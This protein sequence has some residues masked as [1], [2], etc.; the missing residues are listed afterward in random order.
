MTRPRAAYDF[1]AIRARM[2]ELRRE[3]ERAEA[4]EG[5]LHG[6]QPTHRT[7]RERW[8]A[9]EIGTGPG[10][11]RHGLDEQLDWDESWSA[12]SE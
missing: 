4:A 6:D 11:V 1:T 5:E 3:P 7:R 10:R 8:P 9:E 2:V 12:Q